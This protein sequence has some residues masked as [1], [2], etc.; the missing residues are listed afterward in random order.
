MAA[1]APAAREPIS[2]RRAHR[3]GEPPGI[4]GSG[5]KVPREERQAVPRHAEVK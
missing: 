5:R 4:H 2:V 1:P 3:Q